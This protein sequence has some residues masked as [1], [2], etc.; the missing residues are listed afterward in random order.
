MVMCW[1]LRIPTYGPFLG[2]YPPY[3]PTDRPQHATLYTHN[4]LCVACGGRSVAEL[5]VRVHGLPSWEASTSH[6]HCEEGVTSTSDGSSYRT[7]DAQALQWLASA[8]ADNK[9]GGPRSSHPVAGP[10]A[11]AKGLRACLPSG[12]PIY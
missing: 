11:Y 2:T 10:R 5:N 8:P 12:V 9:V 6:D 4:K 7:Y 1:T 3:S